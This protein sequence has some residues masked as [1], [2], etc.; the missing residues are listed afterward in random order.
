MNDMYY[1]WQINPQKILFRVSKQT[2][3]SYPRAAASCKSD[4][5]VTDKQVLFG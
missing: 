5:F 1:V 4:N 3:R 2:V